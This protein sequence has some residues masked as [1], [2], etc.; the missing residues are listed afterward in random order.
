MISNRKNRLALPRRKTKIDK[1]QETEFHENKDGTVIFM[2]VTR[3]LQQSKLKKHVFYT[4]TYIYFFFPKENST[5][6]TAQYTFRIKIYHE[7]FVTS[8]HAYMKGKEMWG[9]KGKAFDL[10]LIIVITVIKKILCNNK[11]IIIMF[12]APCYM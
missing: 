11:E 10:L 7:M 6:K 9:K 12:T 2:D 3:Y 5:I 1:K 8:M 4:Y